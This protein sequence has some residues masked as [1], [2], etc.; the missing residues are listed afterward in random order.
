MSI[1]IYTKNDLEEIVY[2]LKNDNVV[3]AM[4]TDT[5][6]GL[7]CPI[8]Q[9]SIDRIYDIKNRDIK[10]PLGVFVNYDI[11][12]Q[13]I[14]NIIDKNKTNIS[15]FKNLAD[16]YWPGALTILINILDNNNY[17]I[18]A[19]NNK[20]GIRVPKVKFLLDILSYIDIG[21]AQTSCNISGEPEVDNMSEL[22]DKFSKKIDFIIENDDENISNTSSTII[23]LTDNNFN[24]LRQG[25]VVINDRDF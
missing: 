21:L 14:I 3:F 9:K 7:I 20:L 1:K 10:K 24:I 15:K 19:N 13:N 17:K 18:L 6:Y 5:V 25:N 2:R 12:K 16:N 23:D 4:K 22:I 8:N 11:Y